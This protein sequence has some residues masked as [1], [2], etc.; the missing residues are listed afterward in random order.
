M[1]SSMGIKL[2]NSTQR[3]GRNRR[4][5]CLEEFVE[6]APR[7]CPTSGQ[8]DIAASLQLLEAGIALD[9]QHAGEVLEMRRR[10]FAL[11]IRREHEDRS[12]RCGS[13]PW[14][15]VTRIDPE[16]ACL[17][18]ATT[19][20]EHWDWRVI[21]KQMIRRKDVGAKL[22]V[23]RRATSRRRQPSRPASIDR[24]QRRDAQRSATAD[25]AACDRSIC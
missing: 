5:A 23:Q 16:P 3:L 21:R 25:R 8:D 11:A 24:D 9:V 2:A 20:I 7:V 6:V 19:R 10:T 14:P 12:G 18:A 13:T 15:L 1:R 22:F 4:S 17:G